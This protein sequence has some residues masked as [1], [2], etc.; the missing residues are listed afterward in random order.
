MDQSN[1]TNQSILDE[2]NVRRFIKFWPIIPLIALIVWL[3]TGIYTVGA[4]EVGVVQQFGR[5][6]DITAPGLRYHMPR[7]IQNVTIVD[8]DT[9]RSATVGYRVDTGDIRSSVDREALM[10][11][12]DE[13]IIKIHLFVQYIVNDPSNFVFRVRDPE[14]VL[15]SAAEVALRGVVGGYAVDFTMTEGRAEIQE[16]TRQRLQEL[17]DDYNSGLLV[18]EA[19]LLTA[20]PPAQVEDAFHEVVRA[21]EDRERLVEEAEGYREDV[22]PRARGEAARMLADAQAYQE[23]RMLEAQGDAARFTAVYDEYV[24]APAVTRERMY[25]EA[26]ENILGHDRV[27]LIIA[28]S[29]LGGNFLP[30]LNLD[31]VGSQSANRSASGSSASDTNDHNVAPP[32][33]SSDQDSTDTQQGVSPND[34]T[35]ADGSNTG[36]EN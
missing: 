20:D 6:H 21:L 25:L 17:L 3:L 22:V 7:P 36:G 8:M 32:P 15:H 10:L 13:N 12:G 1:Q 27:N 18:R 5:E 11:T 33:V 34:E 9:V 19:R 16:A 31:Q 30:M 26:I 35:D 14:T 23:S 24:R 29:E 4:G 28:D 2:Y